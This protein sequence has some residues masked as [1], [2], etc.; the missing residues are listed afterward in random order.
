MPLPK[1]KLKSNVVKTISFNPYKVNFSH[2]HKEINLWFCLES[3]KGPMLNCCD[4]NGGYDLFFGKDRLGV[5]I[6]SDF[7]LNY[8][9]IKGTISLLKKT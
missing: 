2:E 9:E 7:Q 8:S 4:F 5:Y 6:V 1:V 3:M